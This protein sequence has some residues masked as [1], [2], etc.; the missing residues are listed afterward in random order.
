MGRQPS[1]LCLVFNTQ[2][3]CLQSSFTHNVIRDDFN[4]L[5]PHAY[6][7]LASQRHWHLPDWREEVYTSLLETDSHG[8]QTETSGSWGGLQCL[9]TAILFEHM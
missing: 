2:I 9:G 3:S 7:L 6:V 1:R 8:A 4:G 5:R